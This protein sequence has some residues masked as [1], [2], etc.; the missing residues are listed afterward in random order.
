MRDSTHFGSLVRSAMKL[1][2]K[3][4]FGHKEIIL[5][6]SMGGGW[7]LGAHV[8]SVPSQSESLAQA[9]AGTTIIT[10]S[11]NNAETPTRS[12]NCIDFIVRTAQNERQGK[13]YKKQDATP[14]CQQK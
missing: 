14:R 13:A 3:E 2:L 6:D 5:M 12:R 1:L 7:T 4:D 8:E 9:P 10:T 11:R